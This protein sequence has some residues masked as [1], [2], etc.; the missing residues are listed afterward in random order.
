MLSKPTERRFNSLELFGLQPMRDL[1]QR[2]RPATGEAFIGTS[3]HGLPSAR[4]FFRLLFRA[5][6]ERLTKASTEGLFPSEIDELGARRE[7]MFFQN[8]QNDVIFDDRVYDLHA[9]YLRVL[10][11]L[12]NMRNLAAAAPDCHRKLIQ[13]FCDT[14][15]T[16]MG[17]IRRARTP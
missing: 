5:Y 1:R 10:A 3:Q 13:G 16:L 4:A 9:M 14:V 7:L 2:L 6:G 15:A 17:G 12:K 11:D 8:L